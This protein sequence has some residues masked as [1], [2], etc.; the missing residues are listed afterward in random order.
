MHYD[1]LSVN[2]E[3][4]RVKIII[5][6]RTAKTTTTITTNGSPTISTI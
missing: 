3:I 2:N 4:L 5:I 1:L 6:R